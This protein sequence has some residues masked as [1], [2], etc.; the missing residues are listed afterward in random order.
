MSL[1]KIVVNIKLTAY[2]L[3]E[4]WLI[5]LIVIIKARIIF[6]LHVLYYGFFVQNFNQYD[7]K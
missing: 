2:L 3:Q 4:K 6:I 1:T 5:F 7:I